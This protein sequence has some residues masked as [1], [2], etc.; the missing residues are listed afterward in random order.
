MY[1]VRLFC[2]RTW[3]IFYYRVSISLNFF[4]I[5]YLPIQQNEHSISLCDYFSMFNFYYYSIRCIF[6]Y[7][8]SIYLIFFTY[9][10]FRYNRTSTSY[11][12]AIILAF[13]IFIIILLGTA[14]GPFFKSL[15]ETYSSFFLVFYP[16]LY[17]A[18]VRLHFLGCSGGTPF[19]F[20]IETFLKFHLL[21]YSTYNLFPL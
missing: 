7:T 2:Y 12:C 6:Y 15:N 10:I 11:L 18:S 17:A 8:V 14:A 13:L 4:Y 5:F 3:C 16:V 19:K 20:F 21:F 1:P 9:F